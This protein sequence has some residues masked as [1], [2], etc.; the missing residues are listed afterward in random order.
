[1]DSDDDNNKSN[2]IARPNTIK[3]STNMMETLGA[4]MNSKS[5]LKLIKDHSGR[6]S[7]LRIPIHTL[8]GDRIR[9]NDNISDLTPEIYKTLSSTSYTSKTMKIEND[10]LMMN[11]ILRDLGFTRRGDRQSKRKTFLSKTLPKLVEE[12]QNKTFDEITDSSDELEGQEL[13]I[14]FPS[15]LTDIYNRIEV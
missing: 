10:I 15:N 6:A 13:K 5:T 9:I 1:M 7:I 8:G 3:F 2:L 12:I 11:N 4:L 14:I